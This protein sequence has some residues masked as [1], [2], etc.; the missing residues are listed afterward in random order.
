M[1]YELIILG[2]LMGGPSYGHLIAKI[3]QNITGPYG[4][5]SKGRLYPLLT[6]LEE[7][8]LI[9]AEPDAEPDGDQDNG[10]PRIPSHRYRITTAGQQRFHALMMDTTSYL[11]DYPKVFIQKVA[12]FSFLHPVE[13][14]H[15]IEHYIAYCDTLVSYGTARAA[16]L[17]DTGRDWR[18]R[19]GMTSAQLADLDTVMR[20]TIDHWQRERVWAEG[21]RAHVAVSMAPTDRTVGETS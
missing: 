15:L 4:K 17:S 7:A 3:V 16:A 8:G 10:R 5:I 21:L 9:A 12:R 13:R 2:T 6:R 1:F 20:H 11:G 19:S 14:V 18:D